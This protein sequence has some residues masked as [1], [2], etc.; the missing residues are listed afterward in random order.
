MLIYPTDRILVAIMNNKTDWQQV[1]DEGWYRIPVKNAPEGTPRFDWLAF[2]FTKTF[3]ADKW[4]I[5]YYARIE[6]HELMTR[7]DLIPAQPNHKRANNWYYKLQLGPLQHKIPPIVSSNWRRI[8]FIAT[9]GDRFEAAEEINDLFENES[10]AGWLYVT[11]KEMG[12]HAER[13]FPLKEGG[14]NYV[15]DLAVPAGNKQW[16]P[17]IF[18]SL[19]DITPDAD[20]LY[21]PPDNPLEENLKIVRQA[22]LALKKPS[23]QTQSGSSKYTAG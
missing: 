18:T 7:Q 23:G 8:T 4:A 17:V 15:A 20:V 1:L 22:R 21:L 6:G 12:I 9:T 19:K 16:L 10:P 2:Y 11:L 13:N 5:H 14:V 3:A